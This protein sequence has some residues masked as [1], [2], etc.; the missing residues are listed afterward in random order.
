MAIWIQYKAKPH[1]RQ[2]T[3][4]PQQKLRFC[5]ICGK[6]TAGGNMCQGCSDFIKQKKKEERQAKDDSRRT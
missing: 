3:K 4:K 1:E 5:R 2:S 6:P